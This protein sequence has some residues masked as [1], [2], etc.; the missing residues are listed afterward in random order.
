MASCASKWHGF[1]SCEGVGVAQ[2]WASVNIF[3]KGVSVGDHFGPF[4]H[5]ARNFGC[6][7]H[8]QL[9]ENPWSQ[10]VLK[11]KDL[12]PLQMRTAEFPKE[13]ACNPAVTPVL[14]VLE[15]RRNWQAIIERAEEA[16]RSVTH[17]EAKELELSS[18]VTHNGRQSVSMADLQQLLGA[19]YL[20]QEWVNRVLHALQVDAERNNLKV[21][22][23]QTLESV[24]RIT[25]PMDK[26]T[27]QRVAAQ[28]KLTL[29]E[30]KV[31]VLPLLTESNEGG[32]A[33]GAE[34]GRAWS[35]ITGRP[36][37][38]GKARSDQTP[39]RHAAIVSSKSWARPWPVG[40]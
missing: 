7:H 27:L 23:L 12:L 18:A 28:P 5:P 26:Q 31:F 35:I 3:V 30:N 14:A 38:D 34:K 39:T 40:T 2:R 1:L 29:E 36:T 21:S 11:T 19:A 13:L 22:V 25:S 24:V 6:L 32:G 9:D 10:Y 17:D 16:V 33:E 4:L 15:A 20:S 8:L 37:S